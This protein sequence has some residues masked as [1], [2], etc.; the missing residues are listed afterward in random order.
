MSGQADKH[1]G[2]TAPNCAHHKGSGL[3]C[4][5][6]CEVVSPLEIEQGIGQGL[7][8][9]EGEGF[10]PVPL[11]GVDAT[12]I[13]AITSLISAPKAVPPAASR[14]AAEQAKS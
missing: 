6:G 12:R 2:E 3:A 14:M 13:A 10:D 8:L 5:P 9:E 4:Q 7:Q 1:E 11:V